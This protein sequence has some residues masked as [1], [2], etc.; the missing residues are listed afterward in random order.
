MAVAHADQRLDARR[1]LL[2]RLGVVRHGLAA[3]DLGQLVGLGHETIVG[4]AAATGHADRAT[5]ARPRSGARS[6]S[7]ARP[8]SGARSRSRHLRRHRI[9]S[10]DA[11]HLGEQRL[12]AGMIRRDRQHRLARGARGLG[13]VARRGQAR[14]Q[15]LRSH[16]VGRRG[17]QRLERLGR[18]RRVLVAQRELRLDQR[19]LVDIV[20]AGLAAPREIQ[21]AHH[22]LGSL[23]LQAQHVGHRDVA[24]HG[25]RGVA[26]GELGRLLR[27]GQRRQRQ[28]ATLLAH[29]VRGLA[30]GRQRRFVL[31][32]L[33]L[34]GEQARAQAERDRIIARGDQALLGGDQR[35]RRIAPQLGPRVVDQVGRDRR[36]TGISRAAGVER[37]NRA[38]VDRRR[39]ARGALGLLG[40]A[41]EREVHHRRRRADHHQRPER[42]PQPGAALLARR[43]GERIERAIDVGDHRPSTATAERATGERRVLGPH[44][45]HHA[46]EP[47]LVGA[48][49]RAHRATARPGLG[50]GHRTHRLVG[51]R[52]GRAIS[53]RRRR[54]RRR[55]G[56]RRRGTHR[57]RRLLRREHRRQRDHRGRMGRR[58]R[59][60]RRRR[61]QRRQRRRGG[62]RTSRRA[63]RL[64]D[65]LALGSLHRAH[66][67]RGR[68]RFDRG[69]PRRRD[70]P[71]VGAGLARLLG[72]DEERRQIRDVA[73]A[74][75]GLAAARDHR[76][77][78][79]RARDDPLLQRGQLATAP[80]LAVVLTDDPVA[81]AVAAH[82][83]RARAGLG[84]R[85]RRRY[86]A[87][88]RAGR[89]GIAAPRFGARSD[90]AAR[91][92]R[93]GRAGTHRDAALGRRPPADLEHVPARRA[94]DRDAAR[95]QP[96]FIEFILGLAL[97]AANVHRGISS[98]SLSNT[99][100][101]VI[102][103]TRAS[104]MRPSSRRVVL[105]SCHRAACDPS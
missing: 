2:E 105:P 54:R 38:A 64:H 27:Q 87:G 19:Q 95:L 53:R 59:R 77:A 30:V 52:T 58:R 9:T 71:R 96:S 92:G 16:V 93:A 97:L 42:D 21:V 49:L 8:R 33:G 83:H 11:A 57:R 7:G 99:A 98:V 29:L 41:Q 22:V 13:L 1:P 70:L 25:R 23:A 101:T 55:C 14:R 89:R 81:L 10:I 60:Q 102:L 34:S 88:L 100:P 35:R 15:P 50:L 51:P 65:G 36:T 44:G 67:D 78:R 68:A 39:I 40:R 61:S 37:G 6:R 32:D 104:P 62:Q 31:E 20:G 63:D 45:S 91:R 80:G 48:G 28:L 56:D 94:L 17:E 73:E 86:R 12:G 74:L 69:H 82:R 26:A 85:L 47:W 66:A 3:V 5:G 90:R 4:I 72:D 46:A 24:D 103:R 43:L 75:P 18:P 76:L 84:A 79:H